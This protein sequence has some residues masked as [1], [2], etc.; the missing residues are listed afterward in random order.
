MAQ[1]FKC[2]RCGQQFFWPG[3]DRITVRM[4][5][6]RHRN[7]SEM[8]QAEPKSR[9]DI[10]WEEICADCGDEILFKQGPREAE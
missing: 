2:D 3:Q 6:I 9:F 4:A 10:H 8:P 1:V 7:P 5:L